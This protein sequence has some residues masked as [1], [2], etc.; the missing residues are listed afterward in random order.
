MHKGEGEVQSR[1]AFVLASF[2]ERPD[3][4]VHVDCVLASA[5][6]I[7]TKYYGLQILQDMISARWKRLPRDQ[8]EGIKGFIVQAILEITS[9]ETNVD[10]LYLQKLDLVLVQVST[11]FTNYY[12]KP[13]FL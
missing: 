11:F 7:E 13:F 6:L 10:K 12:V 1:A 5:Q 2:K 3:A 4:W 9:Q 8:A